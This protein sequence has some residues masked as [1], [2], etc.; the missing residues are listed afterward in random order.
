VTRPPR[1]AAPCEPVSKKG[2]GAGALPAGDIER[3]VAADHP[4]PFAV[5]GLHETGG[6]MVVR[7]F[8]PG[9]AAVEVIGP[10]S[11]ETL[12]DLACLHDAGLFAGPVGK[13]KT[14]FAYRLRARRG[15]ATWTLEDPYRFPPLLGELDAH[16]WGEGAHLDAFDKLGAHIMEVEGI[17]GT[18]FAVWAP[19]A[20][21]ISVVG[22]FND[23]D[24]RRHVMRHRGGGGLWEIFLPGVGEGAHYKYEI[25]GR[26]GTVLPLKADPFGFGAEVRPQTASVVRD[27][28]RFEWRDADW[29]NARAESVRRDRPVSIY[30]VHLGSWRR[31]GAGPGDYLSYR[32][33]AV[34]LVPYV[35]DLGFT[36]IELLPISEHPFD[37][38]WGYQ[39]IGLFAPTSRYGTPD[40]FKAFVEACH[41]AGLGLILDWVPGH[42]P[43]DAHGLGNFDGTHL[44]EHADPRQGF[45]QDWNTLIF[46]FGR[47]EV[48]NYLLSNALF[49]LRRYHIDGLRVDA[50]AS[51][52]YLDYSRRAG[53]WVPNR[54]GGNENL[55]AIAFL[56]RMNEVAYGADD[57]IVTIAE[58][59]TA[60]PGVS[61][62]VYAGG[63]GFGYKW[64]M[65]WMNDTLRYM[66][67]DPIHRRY[68]QNEMTFGIHYGFSENFILPLSHD[69]VVH[70]KGSLLGRMLGDDWQRFAN[71]RAY[72]TFMWT[73]PGKKLL[74]MGGEFA[75]VREWNHDSS[76]D[77]H[78]LD[79]AR[80]RGVQTLVRDLN[81]LYREL[82]ALHQR[83]CEATGFQWI[84]SQAPDQS[85]LAYARWGNNGAAPVVVVCNFTPVLHRDYRVGLPRAGQWIE[86]LNSDAE[87]YGGSN[88]GNLGKIASQAVPSHGQPQ[89]MAITVPP[90]AT[91]VFELAT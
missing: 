77:W 76:L 84:E 23:W 32:D 88:Q 57:S 22:D 56:R 12:A 68:H 19:N 1:D 42:F 29:M 25:K 60:W 74:F 66:G 35:K 38:S 64:N 86:R 16:L 41:G 55:E 37:G 33:L 62:P 79:D 53:E 46:N 67:R 24:G 90:L 50:V 26:D 36:H 34:Q 20:V 75:Q 80:H 89:S 72:L 45:H 4:D 31:S 52:L 69:E 10:E 9:A 78:L 28:G 83:D 15:D 70:G 39:P 87:I 18:R 54:E 40:D 85:I 49:W 59:S 71:L 7:A 5:L 58:E 82:P 65:G 91:V 47:N 14:R 2:I 44:Y 27:L 3:I 30:E 48:A 6:R 11:D 13:R 81:G 61:Q 51:M 17:Q 21:R 73:H 43:T 63:L 8:V